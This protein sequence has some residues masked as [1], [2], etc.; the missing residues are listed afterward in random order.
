VD[1]CRRIWKKSPKAEGIASIGLDQVV[2]GQKTKFIRW[3][4]HGD[5]VQ[6]VGTTLMH[7]KV[8]C[9]EIGYSILYLLQINDVDVCKSYIM[10]SDESFNLHHFDRRYV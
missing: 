5:W 3:Q 6:Q 2:N 9:R 4:V 10:L 8:N 7:M 1:F